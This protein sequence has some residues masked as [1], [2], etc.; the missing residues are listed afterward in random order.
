M[1]DTIIFDLGGVLVDWN[2]RYL[3][4]KIFKSEEEITWFKQNIFTPEWN[5]QLDAGRPFSEVAN[6]LALR[7]PH[8]EVVIRAW[9][10]RWMETIRGP[11]H[12]TVEV[13]ERLRKAGHQKLYALTNWSDETFPW[14]LETFEFLHWFDGI[15]VSGIEKTCKP[16]PEL[17]QIL[18]KRY[19]INPSTSVFIDDTLPNVETARTLGIDA[20]HFQGAA[21]LTEELKKRG[22]NIIR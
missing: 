8:H 4:D 7:F 12:D 11:K 17:Y 20:I 22:I 18:L 16:D 15:V 14:A 13:L 9:H 3:Y 10:S 1:I 5:S 19:R 21:L 6:E 2:P